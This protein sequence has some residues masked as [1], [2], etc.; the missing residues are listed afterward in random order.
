VNLVGFSIRKYHEAGSSE[1]E[2]DGKKDKL[3]ETKTLNKIEGK[4]RNGEE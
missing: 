4:N 3:K 1:C 2:T